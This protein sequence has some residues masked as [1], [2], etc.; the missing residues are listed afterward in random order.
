DGLTDEGLEHHDKVDMVFALDISGS[1][2]EEID[3]L[4]SAIARYSNDLA[5]TEHL[6]ALVTFPGG[7]F[8][9]MQ[10]VVNLSPVGTFQA[11]L[12]QLSANGGGEEPSYDVLFRLARDDNPEG[13]MWR[14]D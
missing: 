3:A 11:A 4:R 1:M 5:N 2:I 10:V 14:A 9:P 8:S 6:F 12:G 7:M 13:M